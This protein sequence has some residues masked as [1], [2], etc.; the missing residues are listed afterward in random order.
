MSDAL[1]PYVRVV[2][3]NWNNDWL[4]TR[5]VRSILA[6]DH[7][8]DRLEVV[9]ADNGSID[10]S[11][12]RLRADLPLDSGRVRIV[13]NGANLGFAEGCNRG[14]R[15]L[16]G[17][18]FVA[19]INNDATV[20]A[21]WLGPLLDEMADEEVGAVAPKLLLELPFVTVDLDEI[22]VEEGADRVCPSIDAIRVDGIDM[23]ARCV[24]EGIEVQVHPELPLEFI[25][26][27]RD[28]A[29][30][31]VPVGI[32]ESRPPRIELDVTVDSSGV[33]ASL[34]GMDV[35]VNQPGST[36]IALTSV[37]P[38]HRRINN[39]GTMIMANTEGSDR[40]F[41]VLDRNDLPTFDVPGFC[42]GAVLLRRRCSARSA[43]STPR[44]SRTTRTPISRGGPGGQ[45]GGSCVRPGRW[46]TTCTAARAA[47]RRVGS[48]S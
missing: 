42:G 2:V 32:D 47:R 36:T 3:L 46:S 34:D 6:S 31:H 26:K 25:R 37:G 33:S 23:T 8:A 44:T 9:V 1:V 28:G 10:G 16:D 30:V 19:L 43:C 5:C 4:T 45:A 39:L 29:C 41:G 14:M 11:L 40:W 48:S 15:D 7:P 17:V 13:E 35:V 18:D 12:S 21:G 24:F 22:V 38:R 27:V 20:E